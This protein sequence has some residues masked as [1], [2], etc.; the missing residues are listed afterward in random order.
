M[1]LDD[2]IRKLAAFI[3][4]ELLNGQS[5]WSVGAFGAIAEFHHQREPML[6]PLASAL[7]EFSSV[8]DGGAIRLQIDASTRLIAYEIMSARAGLWLHGAALCLPEIQARMAVR[9]CVTELGTD[10]DAVRAADREAE[11]QVGE[12]RAFETGL[13]QHAPVLRRRRLALAAPLLLGDEAVE[14]RAV[15]LGAHRRE[16]GA[17]AGG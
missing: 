17:A 8:T 10:V 13:R 14:G 9:T 15:E 1:V 5:S 2:D 4:A 16:L 11:V 6:E 3:A 12:Q 7:S